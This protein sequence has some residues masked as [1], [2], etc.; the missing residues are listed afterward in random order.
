MYTL[1]ES[2]LHGRQKGPILLSAVDQDEHL[3]SFKLRY[4]DKA[5][6]ERLCVSWA[7]KRFIA[8]RCL[9]IAIYM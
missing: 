5:I 7:S 4:V 6:A 9:I 3:E 8:E 1:V 2:W